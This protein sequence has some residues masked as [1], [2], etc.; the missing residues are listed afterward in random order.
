MG[1]TPTLPNFVQEVVMNESVNY[2]QTKIGPKDPDV[3]VSRS[4][5]E[6]IESLLAPL[7]SHLSNV[8]MPPCPLVIEIEEKNTS[9]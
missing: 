3:K 1:S 5:L 4:Y 7:K 6:K 9:D 2:I 8:G